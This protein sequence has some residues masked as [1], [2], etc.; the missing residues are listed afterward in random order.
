MLAHRSTFVVWLLSELI[1]AHIALIDCNPAG[2]CKGVR[3]AG[4]SLE[5]RVAGQS[6]IQAGLDFLSLDEHQG[7]LV[8]R[9][10]GEHGVPEED[11]V[12][13]SIVEVLARDRWES[14]LVLLEELE[15]E[16]EEWE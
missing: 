11:F 14:Y 2:T 5:A 13:S 8:L 9:L 3:S 6:Q 12:D 1:L 16:P 15:N 7:E 10:T 4:Y